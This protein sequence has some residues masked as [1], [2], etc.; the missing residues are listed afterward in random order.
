MPI[1]KIDRIVSFSSEDKVHVASNILGSKAA[2]RWKCK[3]P[4]EKHATLVLQL[5]KASVIIGID[6]G[7]EHSAYI[8]VLV[9][10]SGDDADFKTLLPMSS[11]MSAIESRQSTGM[12]RVRMFKQNDLLKPE[13]EEKWDRIKIVCTQPFNKHVQYG[14]SFIKFHTNEV[15]TSDIIKE[16]VETLGGFRLRPDSPNE[17]RAGYLFSKRKELTDDKSSTSVAAAIRASNSSLLNG[18]SNSPARSSRLL[19]ELLKN[20]EKRN[21]KQDIKA[22]DIILKPRHREELFYSEEDDKPNAKIDK[23]I[24]NRDELKKTKNTEN[25][26][27]LPKKQ[28]IKNQEGDVMENSKTPKAKR[29]K[30]SQHAQAGTSSNKKESNKRKLAEQ[31]QISPKKIKTSKKTRPF[32]KLLEDVVLVISGIQNPDRAHIRGKAMEMGAKYKPDWDNTST[33]LICAF[34]NTPKFNQVKGKG[35]IVTRHWVEE[36]YSQR[37]KI[38]WRRF[39][40]DKNETNKAESEDEISEES[41]E[42]KPITQ[43]KNYSQIIDIDTMELASDTEETIERIQNFNFINADNK[44]DKTPENATTSN[45]SISLVS[46]N[47]TVDP[48][49][50][51]TDTDEET[52]IRKEQIKN[53]PFDFFKQMTFYIDNNF[54]DCILDM[55][56]NYIF[57]HE[58]TLLDD[59]KEDVIYIICGKDEAPNFKE[60]NSNAICILPDWIVDCHKCRQFIPPDEYFVL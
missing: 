26:L 17:F 13:C 58:G 52:K 3:L 44:E 8:E 23:L 34:M 31:N 15:R 22:D 16:P 36:C 19:P 18:T 21:K 49:S 2:L 32:N 6:I 24:E 29:N 10:R 40:L 50:A 28:N 5:E 38:P 59:P 41:E 25:A 30:D 51:E 53:K 33:H 12:N 43:K 37:M 4:G 1:L 45:S 14:L 48:Y 27:Q 35:K 57:I 11:F 55:L 54:E 60:I 42:S 7:N 20:S 39:A 46:N 9:S 56:K 47:D